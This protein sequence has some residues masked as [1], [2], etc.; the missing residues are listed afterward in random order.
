[1]TT[2]PATIA[3]IPQ[4]SLQRYWQAIHAGAL[5]AAS[6]LIGQGSTV[7]IAWKAPV[8]ED[9][10]DEQARIVEGF[11][12]QGVQ[13]IVL[14]PFDSRALVGPV[15][16]AARA[17]IPTVVVDSALETQQIVSFIATDNRKGGSL[18]ADRMGE[19]LGGTGSV[20]LLRYQE[21]SASTEDRERGF[22]Q[23]I[24]QAYP[25]IQLIVS[26]E[27]AGTTRESARKIGDAMLARHGNELRGIFTPNESTTAGM[28]L[29]LSGAHKA[30][31][32]SLVGF[33]TSDVYVDSLRYKQLHGLV[34]QDPFRMGELG[35]KTV[36]DHLAGKPVPK[37]IDTGAT[38]VTPENMDQPAI[39]KLLKPPVAK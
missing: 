14:A 8:R 30:G 39:Q 37:R 24:R 26:T 22:A 6:D 19:V 28:L 38:M 9:D 35:V 17:G 5:K 32:I 4:G 27:Y 34:V 31:R 36:A 11:I 23:R 20:L 29:A 1:M 25:N 15:E 18:A 7:Q 21:G 3:V 13:A 33:D 2:R 10:R 12:R 16:S